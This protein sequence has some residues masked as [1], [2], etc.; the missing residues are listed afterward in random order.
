MSVLTVKLVEVPDDQND[1]DTCYYSEDST[2]CLKL[3]N[4]ETELACVW[5]PDDII[6]LYHWKEIIKENQ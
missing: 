5:L 6:K 4:K 2:D 3:G 1:C